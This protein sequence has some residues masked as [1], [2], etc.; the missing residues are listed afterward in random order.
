MTT[1]LPRENDHLFFINREVIVVKIFLSFQLAEVR[2]LSSFET[3]I[4]D[5]NVLNQY[6]DKKSSISIKLL[7]GVV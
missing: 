3:F 2:Y 4:V 1:T 7:G 5:I 6:A